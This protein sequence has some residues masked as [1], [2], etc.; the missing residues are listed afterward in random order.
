MFDVEK[1]ELVR[2]FIEAYNAFDIG[3]MLSVLHPDIEFTNIS[4][5]AITA[6]ACGRHEFERL[7][8]RS[9]EMFRTR[10]QS[11]RSLRMEGG[12]VIAEID[13]EAVPAVGIPGGPGSG[14]RI[15]LKGTSEF[16]FE[17]GL[18]RSIRDES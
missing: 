4:G 12:K 8:R 11:I 15:S 17:D 5:G 14:E 7:A 10:S 18:I 6:R 16:T 3:S 9:A 1:E 2:T 13:F